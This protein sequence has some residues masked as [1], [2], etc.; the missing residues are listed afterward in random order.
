MTSG[1]SG[2]TTANERLLDALSRI[3]RAIQDVENLEALLVAIMEESKSLLSCEASSLFLHDPEKNDLYFEVVVGGAEG[4]RAIRVPLGQ[5]IVGAAGRDKKTITVQD[6]AADERHFKKVDTSS[7]F[8]TRNLIATPMVRDGNLIGV[9]E[10]LNK[11][12]G[13]S[14]DETD[15][16]VLEIMAEHAAAAI[17]KARLI[18]ANIQAQRLAAMGTASA[19]LAHYIKNIL[20][21]WKGSASL[22]DMGLEKQ[23]FDLLNQSWPIMRRATDKISKLVQDMLAVS[24]EREPEREEVDVN[25]MI[26]QIL[27]DSQAHADRV[28]VKLVADLDASLA[29]MQ[30]DPHRMHDSILN[31]VGNAIEALEEHGI[32]DGVVKVKSA[33]SDDG[34]KVLIEVEDNGPGMP[35]EIQQKIFEPFFSTKGS[36]GTGLGLAVVRK[37]IEEH[38]G[39]LNLESELG[40]G[41]MFRIEIPR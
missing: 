1:A 25:E 26:G 17:D 27:Q 19:S 15:A 7:G 5:G 4:V 6:T 8:V 16:K 20:T 38:G 39:R 2:A 29:P 36:R 33:L 3:V 34:K 13:Q 31:L 14:F 37:T 10:V 32:E 40:H 30:L 41:T 24:R 21:Q 22:I 11:T 12:E 23:N 9:L 18:Q 28:G 35:P